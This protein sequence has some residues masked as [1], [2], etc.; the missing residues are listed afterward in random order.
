LDHIIAQQHRGPTTAENLALSCGRCNASKGPNIAGIDPAS[1]LM[2]RLFN[3][4]ADRWEEHFRLEGATIVGLT[5]IGRT[6][7]A[8]L[9]MNQPYAIAARAAL[10]DSGI[11]FD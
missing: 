4:R 9:N 5:A 2:S 8:V 10:I 7:V 6:T 3:P 1:N 11:P